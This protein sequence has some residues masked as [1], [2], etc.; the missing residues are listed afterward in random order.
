M[1]LGFCAQPAPERLHTPRRRRDRTGHVPKHRITRLESSDVL[2][3][4]LDLACCVEPQAMLTR[5]AQPDAHA[6][7]ERFA[8]EVVE[9]A[10]VQRCCVDAHQYLVVFENRT[11]H[12]LQLE[13]TRWAVLCPDE[14][15]HGV[16]SICAGTSS[17]AAANC[18]RHKGS[19]D[20]VGS[21][22]YTG[23]ANLSSGWDGRRIRD[24]WA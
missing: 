9:V 19:R 12:V 5:C 3:N 22:R 14:G 2:A 21:T 24:G 17:A 7:E 23:I 11:V 6:S 20:L 10:L 1:L 16:L 13:N 15:S 4:R 18:R 8:V